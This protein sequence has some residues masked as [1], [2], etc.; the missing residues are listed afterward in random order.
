[1]K[2]ILTLII[3]IL[4]IIAILD[5]VKSSK[6]TVKKALWIAVIIFFPLIGM[7]VYFLIGQGKA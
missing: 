4:D 1:M 6:D 2:T 7:I 5:V 3:L